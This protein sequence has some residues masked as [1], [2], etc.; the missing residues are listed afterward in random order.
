MTNHAWWSPRGLTLSHVAMAIDGLSN[1]S[2]QAIVLP[3]CSLLIKQVK[4]TL[5]TLEENEIKW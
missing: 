4:A 5:V 3:M 1:W 2:M